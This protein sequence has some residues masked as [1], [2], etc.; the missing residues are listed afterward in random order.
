MLYTFRHR[1]NLRQPGAMAIDEGE[2][3]LEMGPPKVT[4]RAGN[5]EKSL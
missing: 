2:W 3:V 5:R 1:F 4:I